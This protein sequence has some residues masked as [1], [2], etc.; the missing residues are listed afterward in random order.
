MIVVVTSLD[1]NDV[2]GPI[3]VGDGRHI[4]PEPTSLGYTIRFE[5]IENA[6]APAAVVRVE[7]SLDE[8]LDWSTF[9]LG[10]LGFGNATISVPAG[11]KYYATRYDA[12][13][14]LG[15]LVDIEGEL[16]EQTGQVL[17]TFT[18]L[19]PETLDL[20]I[21][22]LVGFLPPNNEASV[23]E[24][25]VEYR[26]V[27]KTNLTTGTTIDAQA[28]IFFDLND[29]IDTPVWTNT[30]DAGAPS[31]SVGE[32]PTET[33]SETF[34]VSWT[35]QDDAGG[36]GLAFYD[37][38]VSTNG[39]EF[40]PFLSE[41][42][43]TSAEFNGAFGST[44]SFYSVA[45]DLVGFREEKPP[46]AEATISIVEL[47]N[48]VADAGGPYEV[49]E[50]GSLVLA[51]SAAGGTGELTYSWDL[52]GDGVM[53]VVGADVTFD[54]L[55]LD[56]PT[57][58]EV[59]LRVASDSGDSATDTATIQVLN[60]APIAVL[61]G[62]YETVVGE[63]LE[64]DA[65]ASFDPAD[66][67]L[68]YAWDLD[69]NGQFD[70]ATGE[71]ADFPADSVG[72]FSVA[73]RVT[74]D[75]GGVNVATTEIVVTANN[76]VMPV[77]RGTAED[78]LIKVKL[79]DANDFTVWLNGAVVL[80]S[81]LADVDMLKI[82]ALGGD[83]QV[84]VDSDFPI[85]L[86]IRGGSG[87]DRLF[88]GAAGDHIRGQGGN[89]VIYGRN[90]DNWL[91]GGTGNDYLSGAGGNDTVIGGAGHDVLLGHDGNDIL[92]GGTGEDHLAGGVGDD[93]LQGGHGADVLK[94]GVGNDRLLG[95][96]G[97]DFASGDEGDDLV[98]GHSGN[99]ILFGGAGNDLIKGGSGSDRI[100]AGIGHDLIYGG[101]GHDRILAGD[102][103][104]VVHAGSGRDV[105]LSGA[106][107]D[108]SLGGSGNDIILAGSGDDE[109]FG[110]TG[111]DTLIG[112]PGL[113]VIR[114]G[115]HNDRLFGDFNDVLIGGGGNDS[116]FQPG[117]G[118]EG[119]AADS[120]SSSES[121]ALLDTNNDQFV[122]PIDVLLVI[123]ALN[124]GT[125]TDIDDSLD[126]NADGHLTPLDA[127]LVIN[128]LNRQTPTFALAQLDL[129][130]K[131]HLLEDD[132]DDVADPDQALVLDVEPNEFAMFEASE[133]VYQLAV[134][135]F[136]DLGV[137]EAEPVIDESAEILLHVG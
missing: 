56:G 5:N 92:R 1:P 134:D 97:N 48:L 95:G 49:D 66:D 101:S 103:D 82:L 55:N 86:H 81:P 36:S 104:D 123:N 127:L 28:K 119:D 130:L 114:G 111:R 131:L 126:T 27:Q 68:N 20:P 132:P 133:V 57:T 73:V 65:S 44:Y 13:E 54:A 26:V 107:N 22:P 72:T 8:D 15:V 33:N 80:S 100:V 128:F 113:N 60:V 70:D 51:G 41:V 78:D 52:D 102:G 121:L 25:Y 135:Q 62:S 108:K 61:G 120:L 71:I 11:R 112:Y 85:P 98:I 6:T 43:E 87:N 84:L 32:L 116:Y 2:L 90:G 50:G 136:F 77:V 105:V 16:N 67:G 63:A 110:N 45:T 122:S 115:M 12:T 42:A 79:G 137:S 99:D 118:G 125:Q 18:A 37:V 91:S 129:D 7:H 39:G 106:G 64:L 23:G 83:D 75:D 14:S 17:W 9:E 124:R 89:D 35:G 19:D 30:I 10:N 93:E 117:S 29:P 47:G 3:G 53:D 96:A 94:G 74:D 24:G 46:M 88:G 38:Y 76:P 34:T 58:V 31:S 69:G 21:D 59:T 40:Q 109:L 4:A